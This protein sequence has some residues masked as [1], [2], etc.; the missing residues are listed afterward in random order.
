MIEM[1]WVNMQEITWKAYYCKKKLIA[2]DEWCLTASKFMSSPS[3]MISKKN[4]GRM[5]II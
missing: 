3:K 4:Q 2:L 1:L 5:V